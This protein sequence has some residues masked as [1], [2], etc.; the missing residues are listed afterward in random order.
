MADPNLKTL[1]LSAGNVSFLGPSED[2]G[3]L[4]ALIYFTMSHK[5]SLLQMPYNQVLIP[6]FGSPIRLFSWDL[7]YHPPGIEPNAGIHAWTEAVHRNEDFIS[8]FIAQSLSHL[9]D[10]EAK[11]LLIPNSTIVAGL[12]RGAYAAFLLAAASPSIAGVVAFAPLIDFHGQSLIPLA[13]KLASKWIRGFVSFHD[14]RIHTEHVITFFQALSDKSHR[15]ANPN[16]ELTLYPPIGY[17]GHGTP[18]NIFI[19]AGQAIAKRLAP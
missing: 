2:A 3:P 5:D 14:I 1:A 19:K 16:I 13:P 9:N 6:L 8:P 11:N 15:I 7:P 18:E 17:Q 4:P 10:L 12:S